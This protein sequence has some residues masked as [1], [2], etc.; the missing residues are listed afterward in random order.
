MAA[1]TQT[2]KPQR[3]VVGDLV[4]RV[5]TFTGTTGQTLD[6]GMQNIQWV[7]VEPGSL[8]TAIAISGGTITFTSSAPMT[9]EVVLVLARVG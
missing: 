3:H 2:S 5:F 6:T 1:V 4:L 8:V 9:G 7:G